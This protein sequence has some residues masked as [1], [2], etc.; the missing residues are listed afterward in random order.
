MNP[1]TAPLEEMQFVLREL[2]DIERVMEL[3]DSEALADAQ[4]TS[5]ILSQA[6]RF[7][8]E[9][10][11]PLDSVGDSEGS[12]WTPDG[13]RTAPGFDEAYRQF[14]EAGWNKLSMPAEYGGEGMPKLLCVAV[15]EIFAASN[16]SF[17]MCPDLS[18]N[19]VEALMLAADAS[20]KDL[21]LPMLVS[22]KWS[23]T[24]N[25]T[26]PQAGSDVGA[27]RTRAVPQPDGTY[28]LF[29]QKIFITF[30]EHDLTENI[31]HLVLARTPDAPAGSRGI[32]MFL[33]PKFLP[34][35]G[36]L[37]SRND[38]YCAGIEHKF[39]S[40]GSP[41]CTLVFGAE[42]E[43][44][45]GWL[46]G[47]ENKGLQTMFVMM[48]AARLNVGQ[49][50]TAVGERAFQQALAYARERVQGKA[51]GA[52]DEPVPIIRHPDVRRMLLLMRS[53]VEA[54]RA[55]AYLI[56]GAQDLAERH[57][58]AA[59]RRERQA[60][61]DL[62]TP[63]FKGWATETAVEVASTSIQVHGGA[64]YINESGASQPLR[65][66]RICSIYEGTTAIQAN[67]LVE[68]KL[69]RDQ[70]AALHAWF[71]HVERTL[72]DLSD[73][74]NAELGGM[75]TGLRS[76]VDSLRQASD[77]ILAHYHGQQLEVL[78]GAV[79]FLRMTGIVV[80]GW[81][82]ARA[83]LA[84]KRALAH[85]GGKETD[86]FLRA[87]LASALFYATHVFPQVAGLAQTAMYGG[88]AVLA[89]DEAHF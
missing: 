2:A 62:M 69:V 80:G 25:L 55:V 82:M 73:P 1:Y 58:D 21:Y 52:G 89:M 66:V 70:G 19:A 65:D 22:G 45:V 83:A 67:D 40:N 9:V 61:V 71:A 24:M 33:V 88:A 68:R 3:P 31:V 57:P 8:K 63:I 53:Q 56:A 49:E 30:G 43:G 64:G 26:E 78:A 41:T 87:K 16:K 60:F 37:G 86:A 47:Q 42:G 5:E 18:T 17:C 15:R 10:L 23:A 84:A 39:G 32:S 4:L 46:V 51:T 29:G 85:G 76:A 35:Q 14:V 74:S 7:A 11:A 75:A 34:E 50:G 59:V 6:A 36:G 72:A 27:L 54:M 28:R 44:A 77:W 20:L 13:V 81:Q 38:V 79:P 48:N 12:Q